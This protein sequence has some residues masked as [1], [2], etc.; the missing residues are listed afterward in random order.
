M[1][2]H[3]DSDIARVLRASG[4]R[5]SPSDEMTRAVYEAVH[6]EWRAT[7]DRRRSRRS[8]RVWLAAAASIAVAAVALFVGRNFIHTP[9]ELMA[10]VSRS[11]GVVQ[12]REGDSGDWQGATA[13]Q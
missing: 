6:A 3:D 4:G 9:G 2:E 1:A 13:A 7:V 8:Q 12:V 10:D 5:S 11:V